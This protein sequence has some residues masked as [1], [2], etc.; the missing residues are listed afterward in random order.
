MVEPSGL[1]ASEN[2]VIRKASAT[3]LPDER[4]RDRDCFVVG[5]KEPG[6]NYDVRL[7]I[8]RES[9]DLH[10]YS[11][12]QGRQVIVVELQKK[13]PDDATALRSPTASAA[14]T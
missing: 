5:G 9:F 4:V 7:W 14:A 2:L 8:D 1:F 6:S 3:R 11:V 13:D 10:R 12:A